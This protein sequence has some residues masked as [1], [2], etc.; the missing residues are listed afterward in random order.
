MVRDYVFID[1]CFTF[2]IYLTSF[3]LPNYYFDTPT[4]S[5]NSCGQVQAADIGIMGAPAR[6]KNE[7]TGKMMAVPG[8]KI[9][10]GGRIGEDAHLSLE[11]FKTG[12]PLAEEELIPELVEI[13]KTQF[14]AVDKKVRKRDKLKKLVGLS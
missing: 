11:P 2:D 6:K 5:P 3:L 4:Y 12:V 1:F 7:E 9:F 8:C 14:G 13:L 10:V